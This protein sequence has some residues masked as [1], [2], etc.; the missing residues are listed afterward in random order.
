MAT[1]FDFSAIRPLGSYAAKR[2]PVRIQLDILQPGEQVARPD[3]MFVDENALDRE[4]A[5]EVTLRAVAARAP[6]VVGAN[7]E[8]DDA[9]KRSGRPDL[10]VWHRDGYVPVD[11]K[12]HMTLPAG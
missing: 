4:A 11:I 5:I 12:H 8:P 2:C 3:W 6:V 7:L 1:R 10:L 9:A